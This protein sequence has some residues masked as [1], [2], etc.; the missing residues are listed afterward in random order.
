MGNEESHTNLRLDQPRAALV[1]PALCI[2]LFRNKQ[3]IWMDN[4]DETERKLE[5]NQ[6]EI[7]LPINRTGAG[8]STKIR[9]EAG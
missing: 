9:L 2:T 7:A 4:Y 1:R 3:L 6:E 8:K 5:S